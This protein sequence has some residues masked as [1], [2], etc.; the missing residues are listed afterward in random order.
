[1][2]V[3]VAHGTWF[4]DGSGMGVRHISR[5][6]FTP[7]VKF[8]KIAELN[9]QSDNISK[10]RTRLVKFLIGPVPTLSSKLHET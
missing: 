4:T 6:S 7:D 5:G 1:V 3:P 10:L 8:S 2:R 9:Q